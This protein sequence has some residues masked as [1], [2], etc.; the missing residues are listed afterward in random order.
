MPYRSTLALVATIAS[1]TTACAEG[2]LLGSDGG[3]DGGAG[4][5]GGSSS[6][7]S[8]TNATT[9]A[10]TNTTA[11]ATTNTST[12]A[13]TTS[14]AGAGPSTTAG[15]GP[16][17]SAANASAASG[18]ACGPTEAPCP[19]GGCFDVLLELCD[20]V[21]NCTDGFDEDPMLCGTSTG[22]GGTPPMGWT[23]TP[24]YYG[25]QLCDCGCGVQDSDCPTGNASECEY[26]DDL[27]SCAVD[28]IGCTDINPTM[29]WLCVP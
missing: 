4:G 11:G 21:Q 25:D 9:G 24:G 16:T 15:T 20:G 28:T 14:S 12:S 17:T 2:T 18:G 5:D 26:C 10:T 19:G 27:N 1:L 29:N 22:S 13:T 6:V 3:G 23:C 7:G 8:T